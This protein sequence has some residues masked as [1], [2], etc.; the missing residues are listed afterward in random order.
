MFLTILPFLVPNIS[1]PTVENET[2]YP[3]TKPYDES[4]LQVSDLHR[5]HYREFGNPEGIPVVVLHGGP[6]F[7]CADIWSSFFDP[8]KYRVI[9][10]DQRG[11]QRSTPSAEMQGNT[12]QDL[13]EDMEKLR[14]HVSVDKWYV[15]GGSWGSTLS[16]LYSEKH[17]DRVWGLILRGVFLARAKDSLNV[18]YG[19]RNTY[20][21]VWDNMV[22][23]IGE[24]EDS[25]LIS[26]IYKMLMDLDPEIHMR[27]ARALMVYD[28]ICAF[29]KPDADLVAKAVDNDQMTLTVAR[30]FTHYAINHF[31]IE[32][33]QILQHI[34]KIKDI[35][36]IIVQGRYDVICPPAQAYELHKRLTN[37]KLWIIQDAGHSSSEPSIAKAL[38]RAMDVI[39]D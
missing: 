6:G 32:E 25:D 18:F 9:M 19:M 12:P 30:T 38:K 27:A 13:V 1:I 7:G 33:D 2:L 34:D 22:Q 15:F 29:L 39:V 16:L 26:T 24:K 35:P 31:F 23:E 14:K 3:A 20:P 28:T 17:P 8:E 4:Y 36:A 5:I 10:F 21:E 37:S 11:A